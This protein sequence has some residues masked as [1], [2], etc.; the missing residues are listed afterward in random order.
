MSQ[1]FYLR[2]F[3]AQVSQ[4]LFLADLTFYNL[5]VLYEQKR[6][7]THISTSSV[8]KYHKTCS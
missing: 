2:E 1:N 3:C 4:I 8:H 5:L 7:K 6:Q